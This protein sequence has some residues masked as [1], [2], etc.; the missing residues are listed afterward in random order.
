MNNKNINLIQ[1]ISSHSIPDGFI[2]VTDNPLQVLSSEQKVALNRKGNELF[3]NGKIIEASRL[4]ITTGYSDG[5][6]RVGDFFMKKK[7]EVK[8]LKYYV[9][10]KNKAK[11]SPIYEKLAKTISVLVKTE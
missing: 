4:F 6:T 5:L 10:A 9:L 3:N 8:A 2:K 7:E 1:Q 11:C